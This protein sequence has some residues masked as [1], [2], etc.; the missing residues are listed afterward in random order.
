MESVGETDQDEVGS[1]L[2]QRIVLPPSQWEAW[3]ISL[4]HTPHDIERTVLA[5][6]CAF[7]AVKKA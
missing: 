1:M 2:A 5:A 3:F 4:A 7:E 6:R